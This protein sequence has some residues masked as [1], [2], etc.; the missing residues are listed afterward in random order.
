MTT[1]DKERLKASIFE[2]VPHRLLWANG[3]VM[4]LIALLA[5]S[6]AASLVWMRNSG[7]APDDI[8]A[9]LGKN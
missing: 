1:K 7:L 9:L 6:L 4:A 3:L 8:F 5:L 2:P